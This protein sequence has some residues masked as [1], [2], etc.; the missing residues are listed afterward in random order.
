[1]QARQAQHIQ[2]TVTGSQHTAVRYQPDLHL[3]DSDDELD[4]SSAVQEAA[5]HWDTTDKVSDTG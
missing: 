4:P 5:A 2:G 1:M 3:N